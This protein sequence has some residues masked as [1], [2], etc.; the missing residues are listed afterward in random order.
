MS[1]HELLELDH[2]TSLPKS[3]LIVPVL[4]SGGAGTRLWPLSREA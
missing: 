4:L 2:K 1:V 3:G